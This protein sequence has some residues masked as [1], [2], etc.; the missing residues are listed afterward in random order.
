MN[1]SLPLVLAA[2][3]VVGFGAGALVPRP[4]PGPVSSSPPVATRSVERVER[5]VAAGLS[6]ADVARLRDEVITAVQ[7]ELAVADGPAAAAPVPAPPTA[8]QTEAVKSGL[9]LVKTAI[10]HGRWTEDDA[11]ALRLQFSAMTDEGRDGALSQLAMAINS[12][13]LKLETQGQLF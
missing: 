8:E 2:G 1:V 5:C 10:E 9:Q 7:G 12:G 4:G 3:L 6:D 13:R 11:A